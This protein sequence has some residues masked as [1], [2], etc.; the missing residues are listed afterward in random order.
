MR[1]L[2]DSDPISTCLPA[3]RDARVRDKPYDRQGTGQ[4]DDPATTVTRAVG[5]GPARPR[6][7]GPTLPRIWHVLREE[8]PAYTAGLASFKAKMGFYHP[9]TCTELFAVTLS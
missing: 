1:S 8:D 2:H 5:R 6:A 3:S 7:A 9:T 4:G